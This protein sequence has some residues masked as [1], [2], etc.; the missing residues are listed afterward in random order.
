VNGASGDVFRAPKRD[1]HGDAINLDG[2]PVGLTDRDGNAFIGTI[3]NIVVG[4]MS[5]VRV[6]DREEAS[7]I[8]GMLGILKT[9]SPRVQLGDRIVIDGVR[10]EVRSQPQWTHKHSMSGTDFPRIWVDVTA[11]IGVP[12]G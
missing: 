4:A 10:Y 3:N 2:S 1:R 5:A 9:S 11:R 12:N 7:D 6:N 8:N